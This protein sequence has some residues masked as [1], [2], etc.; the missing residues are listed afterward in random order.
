MASTKGILLLVAVACLLNIGTMWLARWAA[1]VDS[2][3]LIKASIDVAFARATP[4]EEQVARAATFMDPMIRNY[5]LV[6]VITTTVWLLVLTTVFFVAFRMIET[7]PTWKMVFGAVALAAV[8]QAAATLVLT[9]I[10]VAGQTPT[11]TE[12]MTGGFMVTNAAGMLP[13]DSPAAL[14]ALL[15]RL[16][17]LTL[18]FLIVLGVT[19]ADRMPPKTS[20]NAIAGVIAGCFAL[21][22][23]GAVTMA[24]VMPSMVMR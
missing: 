4:T 6:T 20:R 14:V 16:D 18:I 3:A 15:R 10:A 22:T 11:T 13:E 7:P 24:F 23:A 2:D 1:G 12:L 19:L 21:W 8:C 9:G 5:P 17:V